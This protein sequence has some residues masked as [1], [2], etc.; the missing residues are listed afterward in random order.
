MKRWIIN[1]IAGIAL[2]AA[3]SASAISLMTEKSE[4][5]LGKKLHPRI[6][7]EIGPYADPELQEYVNAVGQELAKL[8][9]R[10]HL[11]YHFTSSAL[12]V[13][14]GTTTNTSRAASL[15]SEIDCTWEARPPTRQLVGNF[16]LIPN[17]AL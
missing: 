16:I 7:A 13:R 5:A 17:L 14:P 9:D 11:E 4:I 6:L 2:G 10:P 15:S 1:T 8:S 3:T 12:M